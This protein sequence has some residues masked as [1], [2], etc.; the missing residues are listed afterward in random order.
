MKVTRLTTTYKHTHTH[1]HTD[2][3]PAPATSVAGQAVCTGARLGADL[4]TT[5][6]WQV[7]LYPMV[8]VGKRSSIGVCGTRLAVIEGTVLASLVR[9]IL[10][11]YT[12][13]S[14]ATICY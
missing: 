9:I 11:H 8:L 7:A 12:E 13:T 14:R 2:L 1:L 3:H 5:T 4:T 6:G 10:A